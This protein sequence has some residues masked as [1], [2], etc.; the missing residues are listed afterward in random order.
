MDG[1][2]ILIAL[3]VATVSCV[4]EGGGSARSRTLVFRRSEQLGWLG[5]GGKWGSH[6]FWLVAWH[7]FSG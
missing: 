5:P 6:E 1:G 3:M 2:G 7:C 4:V